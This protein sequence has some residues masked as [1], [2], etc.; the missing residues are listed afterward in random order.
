MKRVKIRIFI[1]LVFLTNY[2]DSFCGQISHRKKISSR[3]VKIF[4]KYIR[5]VWKIW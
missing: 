2:L 5:I 4:K 1:K 3:I